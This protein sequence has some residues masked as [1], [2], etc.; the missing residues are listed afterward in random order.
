MLLFTIYGDE[1]EMFSVVY[2]EEDESVLGTV[3]YGVKIGAR[4]ALDS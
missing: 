2:V 4:Q 1:C 3:A